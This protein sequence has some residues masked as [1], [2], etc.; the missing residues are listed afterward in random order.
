MGMLWGPGTSVTLCVGPLGPARLLLVLEGEG[1]AA[2]HFCFLLS[3]S[4]PISTPLT[5]KSEVEV[6]AGSIFT[7]SKSR[8]KDK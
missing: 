1:R 4:T 6:W 7:S 2:L 5:V 8:F 3:I